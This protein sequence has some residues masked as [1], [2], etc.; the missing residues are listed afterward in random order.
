MLIKSNK[1]EFLYILIGGKIKAGWGNEIHVGW[2]TYP[3][4]NIHY[5]SIPYALKCLISEYLD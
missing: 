1:W 4:V 5:L 2:I 3:P